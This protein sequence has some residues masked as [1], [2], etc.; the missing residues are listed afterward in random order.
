M[1]RMTLRLWEKPMTGGEGAKTV[2]LEKHNRDV[3]GRT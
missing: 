1:W 2:D 3:A